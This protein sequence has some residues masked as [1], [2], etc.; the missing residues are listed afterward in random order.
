MYRTNRRHPRN[1][2]FCAEG[3]MLSR[4]KAYVWTRVLSTRGFSNADI[5]E[6]FLI[7]YAGDPSKLP[8]ISVSE[9]RHSDFSTRYDFYGQPLRSYISAIPRQMINYP[10]VLAD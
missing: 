5:T 3:M 10:P 2:E 6:L 7:N 4:K 1:R 9:S 8:P